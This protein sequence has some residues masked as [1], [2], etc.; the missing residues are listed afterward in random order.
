MYGRH[1]AVSTI[2][3]IL[4]LSLANSSCLVYASGRSP[5]TVSAPSS[6]ERNV[7]IDQVGVARTFRIDFGTVDASAKQMIA[8]ARLKNLGESPIVVSRLQNSCGC[9]STEVVGSE[10][11][12]A[13][14]IDPGEYTD[15]KMTLVAEGQRGDVTR[16]SRVMLT[17]RDTPAAIIELHVRIK[18]F[19]R[20]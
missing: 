19:I 17:N 7:C 10:R 16:Y 12:T 1:H 4:A 20:K 6:A 11:N 5:H 8:F 13:F 14:A 3:T 2:A 9:L 18:A 15:V